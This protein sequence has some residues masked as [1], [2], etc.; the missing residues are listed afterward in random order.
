[1]RGGRDSLTI[2]IPGRCEASN[3]E[4]GDY[5][6]RTIAARF[7]V[8]ANARPGMTKFS[9]ATPRQPPHHLVELLEV[10]VADLHGAAGIA[11]VD[12]DGQ[13][14]RVADALLQRDR[15]GVL[16]LGCAARLLCLS[17]RHALVMRQRL[18]L[19]HV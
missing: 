10:A 14:Q 8:R 18:G 19:A 13:A 1:M 7:R 4:S 5:F 11:M 9:S 3:P 15:V 16:L 17:C 6:L 12:A 2:V